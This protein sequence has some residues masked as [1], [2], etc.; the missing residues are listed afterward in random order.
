MTKFVFAMAQT[1]QDNDARKNKCLAWKMGGGRVYRKWFS[2][3]SECF[4][5]LHPCDGSVCLG[6]FKWISWGVATVSDGLRQEVGWS[7]SNYNCAHMALISGTLCMPYQITGHH[8]WIKGV[9]VDRRQPSSS[10]STSKKGIFHINIKHFSPLFW[11]EI[12]E[13]TGS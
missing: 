8:L 5:V 12:V 3:G 11:F 6:M 2:W 13:M 1:S 4:Q 9:W 7:G 10:P